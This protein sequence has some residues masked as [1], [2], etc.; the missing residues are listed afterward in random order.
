MELTHRHSSFTPVVSCLNDETNKM[1][2][3]L[4]NLEHDLGINNNDIDNP[5]S[6]SNILF[7]EEDQ[8]TTHVNRNVTG[9]HLDP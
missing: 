6:L 2:N 7:L 4:P 1:P 3:P 9:L 5:M 8:L